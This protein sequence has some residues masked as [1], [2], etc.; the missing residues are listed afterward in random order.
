MQRRSGERRD[1]YRGIYRAACL[2]LFAKRTSVVM[3][4][5]VIRD[6]SLRD[7]TTNSPRRLT[8][9]RSKRMTRINPDNPELPRE[10]LQLLQREGEALVVRMAVD[11]GIKLCG[12]EIAV[13]H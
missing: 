11:V 10:E 6:G 8:K 2:K 13:D 12:E 4:P 7:S 3:A 9:R 5:G 1:P